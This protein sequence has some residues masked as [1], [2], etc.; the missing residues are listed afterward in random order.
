MFEVNDLNRYYINSIFI[1]DKDYSINN[2]CKK[3]FFTIT[4]FSLDNIIA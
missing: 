1:F 3:M 2:T 4:E